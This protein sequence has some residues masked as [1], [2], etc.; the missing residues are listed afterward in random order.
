[1]G[2]EL[3][4]FWGMEAEV[5]GGFLT[6]GLYAGGA[7]TLDI[8]P[9]DWFTL[10]LGPFV[11]E[12]LNF[13]TTTSVGGTLRLDFHPGASRTPT[14]RN[15]FTIGVVGDLGAAVGTLEAEPVGALYLTLG[16]AHY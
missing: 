5:H 16:Y 2:V 11:D 13:L 6:S 3:T 1:M 10:A 9:L 12:D 7:V 14:G 8:T 15:A 4:D